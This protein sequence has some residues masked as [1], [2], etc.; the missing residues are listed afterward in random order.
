MLCIRWSAPPA[1]ASPRAAAL[2]AGPLVFIPQVVSRPS[3]GVRVLEKCPRGWV[4]LWP[5]Q[6]PASQVGRARV[7]ML[8]VSSRSS[9]S[10]YSR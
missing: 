1:F 7:L 5:G 10:G 8:A 6:G 4:S 3:G 2:R 9:R